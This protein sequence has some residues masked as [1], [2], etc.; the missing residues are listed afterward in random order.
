MRPRA[1]LRAIPVV[2]AN[3]PIQSRALLDRFQRRHLDEYPA[4]G[5]SRRASEQSHPSRAA[6]RLQ[7]VRARACAGN[8]ASPVR[9]Q[10]RL[11]RVRTLPAELRS[12]RPR[13]TPEDDLQIALVEHI[14]WRIMPRVIFFHVPNGGARSK[15]TGGRL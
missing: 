5:R 1:N 13:K 9:W 15:A 8:A 2:A 3:D 11:M 7:E 14:R 4:A 10:R 6:A 12:T